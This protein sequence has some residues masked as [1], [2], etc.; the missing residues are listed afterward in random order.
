MVYEYVRDVWLDLTLSP[1][2]VT[3]TYPKAMIGRVFVNGTQVFPGGRSAE[4][5]PGSTVK[6]DVEI[7][8]VGERDGSI[9]CGLAYA[10]TEEPIPGGEVQVKYV[11]VGQK[12]TF[13]FNIRMPSQTLR[14]RINAG[15][16]EYVEGPII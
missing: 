3:P 4:A 6:I 7:I 12:N 13:T 5:V 10:D 14:V 2:V 1:K 16:I 11:G 8:N 9:W 15:H